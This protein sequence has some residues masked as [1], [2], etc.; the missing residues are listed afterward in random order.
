MCPRGSRNLPTCV[1]SRPPAIMGTNQEEMWPDDPAWLGSAQQPAGV[2]GL[3]SR[4]LSA[5]APP[6]GDGRQLQPIQ[7][8]ILK[9]GKRERLLKTGWKLRINSH[10]P[11]KVRI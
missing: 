9:L 6:G 2:H 8:H 4:R 3:G 7:P 10:F 5:V 11:Y 1:N